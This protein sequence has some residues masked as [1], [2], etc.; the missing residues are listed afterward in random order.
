VG[1]QLVRSGI[2]SNRQLFRDQYL[3]FGRPPAALGRRTGYYMDMVEGDPAAASHAYTSYLVSIFRTQRQAE[4]ALDIRWNIWFAV[5]YYST[6][7]PAPISLGD[8]GTEA[9]FHT[10]DPSQPPLSELFFQ[11]GSILVEVFQGSVGIGSTN[12]QLHS[13]WTI[14]TELDTLASQHPRGS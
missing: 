6:P 7:A 8:A 9:L 11:R 3:H 2:E 4:A 14:A 1:S 10:V 5:A 12:D 13:L